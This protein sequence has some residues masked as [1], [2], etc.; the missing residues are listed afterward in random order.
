MSVVLGFIAIMTLIVGWWFAQQG[1]AVKPWLQVD[2]PAGA[3]QPDGPRYAPAQIGLG[4]FLAVVGS[5]FA[6]LITGYLLRSEGGD[7]RTMPLPWLV[8]PNTFALVASGA[9]L[10]WALSAARA[11]A[12]D[13]ARRGVLF[14]LAGTALFL[15]GQFVTWR[16]LAA[17][18]NFVNSG[19]AD[20]FFYLMTAAHGLHIIGGM[21]ALARSHDR[22]VRGERIDRIQISVELSAIYMLFMLF[23]WVLLLTVLSG[24]AA[25]FLALCGELLFEG[26]V[27]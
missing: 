2:G 5:L 1:L 7:W 18:G 14:A 8:W 13:K 9:A 24:G 26:G 3:I 23:V 27:P 20:S 11:G 12:L 21:V 25:E 22:I 17:S 4:V 6:L 19:P 16:M 10:E 15:V